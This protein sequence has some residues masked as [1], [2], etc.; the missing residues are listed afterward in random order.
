MSKIS[1]YNFNLYNCNA[2]NLKRKISSKS[3]NDVY[4]KE[5]NNK[6]ENKK[7]NSRA[8]SSQRENSLNYNKNTNTDNYKI[9]NKNVNQ[10]DIDYKAEFQYQN[11]NYGNSEQRVEKVFDS[12]NT[13][14]NLEKHLIYNEEDSNLIYSTPKKISLSD[15]NNKIKLDLSENKGVD[16]NKISNIISI[17]E[18]RKNFSTETKNN[19]NNIIKNINIKKFKYN[20][21]QAKN[22]FKNIYKNKYD[23]NE[24]IDSFLNTKEGSKISISE[25]NKTLINIKKNEK[26]NKLSINT[27]NKFLALNKN[28]IK[29]IQPWK[30]SFYNNFNNRKNNNNDDIIDLI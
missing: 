26:I 16:K 1:K 9:K 24:I 20:L 10:Y 29:M 6:Y 5:E 13:D 2:P 8:D 18:K 15:K 25:K 23:K 27:N 19:A 28:N 7:N 4:M 11:M 12:K 21:K 17:Y 30:F 3:N 14:N 22:N